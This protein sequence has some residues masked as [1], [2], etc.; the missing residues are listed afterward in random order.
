VVLRAAV[1]AVGAVGAVRAFP[2]SGV[3]TVC[4]GVV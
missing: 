2:V 1:G 4:D 3:V